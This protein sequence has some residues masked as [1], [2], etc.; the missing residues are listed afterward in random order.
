MSVSPIIHMKIVSPKNLYLQ[1]E[2]DHLLLKL[3]VTLNNA[4]SIPVLSNGI[5]LSSNPLFIVF[6]D[7]TNKLS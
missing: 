4:P 6:A 7:V 2:G 3:I 5:P 1:D